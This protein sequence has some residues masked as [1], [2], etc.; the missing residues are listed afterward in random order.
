MT[1]T[2]TVGSAYYDAFI[3]YNRADRDWVRSVLVPRLEGE[4]LRVYD[5]LRDSELGSLLVESIGAAVA[6][7]SRILLVITP[8]WLDS[9]WTRFETALI[10][11]D[12]LRNT[13]RR[14]VPLLLAPRSSRTT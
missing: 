12:N 1:A 5:Y 11:T 8:S 9:D 4:G 7:S 6:H 10:Q 13:K 14:I 2:E 3:S